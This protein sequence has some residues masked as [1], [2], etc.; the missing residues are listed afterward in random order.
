VRLEKVTLANVCER[1][2]YVVQNRVVRL[3]LGSAKL[4]VLVASGSAPQYSP[5]RGSPTI[6]DGRFH[7]PSRSSRAIREA[8]RSMA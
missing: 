3:I 1:Y 4:G 5:R 7:A 8:G 2:F 6:S